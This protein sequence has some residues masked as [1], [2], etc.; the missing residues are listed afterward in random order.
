MNAD[1]TGLTQLTLSNGGGVLSAAISSN[2]QKVDLNGEIFLS[3]TDG[4]GLKQLT[5]TTGGDPDNFGG[6][7]HP[8]LDPRGQKVAFSS[9]RDL[10]AG[11]NT[12]GTTSYF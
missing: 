1:G 4:A 7:S 11:H 12:D 6:N 10:V 2:G 9:D 5:H 8:R 3:N